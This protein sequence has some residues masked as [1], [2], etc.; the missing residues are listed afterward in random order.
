MKEN[1][2]KEC[3]ICRGTGNYYANC[4]LCDDTGLE[5]KNITAKQQY[6]I[7]IVNGLKEK[8]TISHQIKTSQILYRDG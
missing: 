5:P 1:L 6:Y 2:R 7:E 8:L 4:F 3:R